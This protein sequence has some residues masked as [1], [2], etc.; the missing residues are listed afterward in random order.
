M[1]DW[2]MDYFKVIT[3]VAKETG[4]NYFNFQDLQLNGYFDNTIKY[5]M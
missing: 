1:T 2:W 5:H 3:A 4:V